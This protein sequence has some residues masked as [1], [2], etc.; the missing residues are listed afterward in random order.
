MAGWGPKFWDQ[1]KM[2]FVPD[3][4]HI[5]PYENARRS[6]KVEKARPL[7]LYCPSIEGSYYSVFWIRC[8]CSWWGSPFMQATNFL[9]FIR[10]GL[11]C[12]GFEAMS[13][14]PKLWRSAPRHWWVDQNLGAWLQ[15]P[16]APWST[17]IV[18]LSTK[19]I[20]SWFKQSLWCSI[21]SGWVVKRTFAASLQQ[22]SGALTNT[23][24]FDPRTP[25]VTHCLISTKDNVAY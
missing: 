25:C 2:F 14:S 17:L 24:V 5:G 19:D 13:F 18:I 7:I 1:P 4:Y 8:S 23:F 21:A 15:N 22:N 12:S 20:A 6:W 3:T 10:Q 11:W 9:V 16:G